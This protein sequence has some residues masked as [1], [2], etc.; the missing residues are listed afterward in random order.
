MSRIGLKPVAVPGNVTVTIESGDVTVKGPKGE[1][2]T[3]IASSL[4]VKQEDGTLSIERPDNDRLN[5]SQHGL[6]RTLINN[7]VEGVTN[8]HLKTLEIHGVGY[9]AAL[10]GRTLVLSL[11]YSHQIKMNPPSG[12]DFEIKQEDK[13]RITTIVVKGIDKALVGQV[14]ADIRKTRKPDPYKGKGVRYQG[15]VVKLRPGK[16]AGK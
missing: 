5:R 8:G 12:V 7:M 15:E 9:R 10:E 2:K 11:G 16:R 1:L 4:T 6:A 13:S 14:A 3:K